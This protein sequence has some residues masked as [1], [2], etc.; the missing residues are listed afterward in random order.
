MDQT[1]VE[2]SVVLTGATGEAFD[3]LADL[4]L[5]PYPGRFQLYCGIDTHDIGKPDYSTRA[6]A[7]LIRCYRHGARGVGELTDKGTGFS[8]DPHLARAPV[9]TRTIHAST[10]SGK[11]ARS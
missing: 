10:C 11:N 3:K 8:G 4:Y 7:E 6:V 1:G 2:T 5:R 9:C